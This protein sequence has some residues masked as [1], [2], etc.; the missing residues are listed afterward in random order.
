MAR[1][2]TRSSPSSA[3]PTQSPASSRASVST[4]CRPSR[5]AA[6]LSATAS[7]SP[8]PTAGCARNAEPPCSHGL[9]F[10]SARDEHQVAQRL[11]NLIDAWDRAASPVRVSKVTSKGP[12]QADAH[13]ETLVGEQNVPERRREGD[14]CLD[15]ARIGPVGLLCRVIDQRQL[16]ILSRRQR[17]KPVSPCGVLPKKAIPSGR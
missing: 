15:A 7:R 6:S 17:G 3:G 8:Q 4:P 11:I 12:K 13:H 2:R 9:L 16:A 5:E 10:A 14:V 1:R